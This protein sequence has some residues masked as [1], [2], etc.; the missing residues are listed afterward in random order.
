[1]PSNYVKSSLARWLRWFALALV[2][3]VACAF[4]ANWQLNRRE[5]VVK[6]IERIDRNYSHQRV[7]LEVMVPNLAEFKLSRQYRKVWVHGHYLVS[8]ANL[9]RNRPQNG[10]QGFEQIVPFA[11]DN[12]KVIE[13]DRGWL[14]A[15]QSPARPD[16]IPVIPTGDLYLDGRLQAGEAPAGNN[17][18]PH[19]VMSIDLPK[20]AK[21]AGVPKSDFYTGAYL[22][23]SA[24]APSPKGAVPLKAVR[25][26][27]TEGNHLSYAF[28]WV[29]FAIMAFIALG[30]AIRQ[31]KQHRR[32]ASDPNFV[33]KKRKR[34]GDDD[35][36]VE[37]AL[38]RD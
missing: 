13:V 24:E 10:S 5:Q 35:K 17:T 29:I 33:I 12:G 32:A 26:D 36:A 11:M 6:V 31:E 1:M 9:V 20:L 16:V 27:I 28:Q 7:R 38:L 14:I 8:Q 25:P 15:G 37:D 22:Q 3:A 21:L 30:W 19:Q 23:L 18:P 2:F 4:L 34:V